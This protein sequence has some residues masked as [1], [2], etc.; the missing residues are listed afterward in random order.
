M[1]LDATDSPGPVPLRGETGRGRTGPA[2]EG[3]KLSQS[4]VFGK[5]RLG[6]M[7]GRRFLRRVAARPWF[8]RVGMIRP[9]DG[10][11]A[12]LGGY[13]NRSTSGRMLRL[14]VDGDSQD[15]P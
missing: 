3:D 6:R 10:R 7:K 15:R 1:H 2:L 11:R 8:R 12:P 5:A 13:S 14:A 4:D 9:P